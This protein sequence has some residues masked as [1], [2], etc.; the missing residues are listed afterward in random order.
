[1]TTKKTALSTAKLDLCYILAGH[2]R[3]K[4][5]AGKTWDEQ[6][7]GNEDYQQK[8]AGIADALKKADT[9]YVVHMPRWMGFAGTFY[10][11]KETKTESLLFYWVDSNG[12]KII[13]GRIKYTVNTPS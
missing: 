2:Y 1:M 6:F 5:V 13:Y 12:N 8:C 9:P 3:C 4:I 7:E 10:V 11:I